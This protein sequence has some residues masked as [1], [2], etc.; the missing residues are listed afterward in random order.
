MPIDEQTLTEHLQNLAPFEDA[1][2]ARRA[3]DATLEALRSGL[4]DDEADWLAVDLGPQLSEPL[5]R[6]GYTGELSMN[7]FYRRTGRYAGLRRSA[8]TEQAQLVCR[9]LA[10]LLPQPGILRLRKHLPEL[11]PLFSVPE[12]PAPAQGPQR[13][14]N[15]PGVDRTLAGGK[16]GSERPLS[17]AGS[18]SERAFSGAGVMR[19]H[20]DSVARAQ[21][22]H[23]DTKLSSARGLTQERE[24]ESIASSRRGLH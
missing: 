4:T 13:L 16:S 10:E 14:R 6:Q 1:G 2:A 20:S 9:V 5:L 15:D 7:E 22:P 21:N 3:F 24:R 23:E 19:A 11:A 18:P 17:D 8:A 12:A